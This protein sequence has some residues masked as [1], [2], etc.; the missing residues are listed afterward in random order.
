MEGETWGGKRRTAE[1]PNTNYQIRITKYEHR[2]LNFQLRAGSAAGRLRFPN[3]Q[4]TNFK[5]P[6]SNF[7]L[8]TSNFQL[9]TSNY[10]LP[11]SGGRVEEGVE[12][13]G[14]LEAE[15]FD[16]GDGLGCRRAQA[17]DRAEVFEQDGAAF[18][19][20]TGEVVED[21]FPYPAAP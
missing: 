19:A 9:P 13:G 10:Q 6:T 1:L 17:I 12:L 7:K 18:G 3:F 2:T 8:P 15:A 11:T 4:T 16:L 5:L 21:A 14:E 20:E